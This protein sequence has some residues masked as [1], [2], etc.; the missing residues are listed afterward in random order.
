MPLFC[1]QKSKE[2]SLPPPT[3]RR[4]QPL[5]GLSL[6]SGNPEP[7]IPSPWHRCFILLSKANPKPLLPPTYPD[8]CSSPLSFT[9]W[10]SLLG[11]GPS[12]SCSL[13]PGLR[14][15]SIGS[16]LKLGDFRAVSRDKGSSKSTSVPRPWFVTWEPTHITH[17][18]N[19]APQEGK[20]VQNSEGKPSTVNHWYIPLDPAREKGWFPLQ[21]FLIPSA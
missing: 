15:V 21:V 11:L 4:T 1:K 10:G 14:S 2:I 16:S 5:L 3:S 6:H 12:S 13:G 19:R 18:H 7:E 20:L 17:H 9:A 8:N